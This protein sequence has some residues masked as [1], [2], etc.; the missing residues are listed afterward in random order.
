MEGLYEQFNRKGA[1]F[2]FNKF[3]V[4]F[5]ICVCEVRASV[6]PLIKDSLHVVPAYLLIS[7]AVI[8]V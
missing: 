7:R 3:H 8:K 1:F 2:S 4:V 5:K 6:E